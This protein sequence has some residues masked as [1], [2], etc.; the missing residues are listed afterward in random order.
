MERKTESTADTSSSPFTAL[1]ELVVSEDWR[2]VVVLTGAS[3]GI[4]FATVK[5]LISRQVFVFATVRRAEDARRVA[6]LGA[7]A[8]PV[9][10]DICDAER[11]RIV[12][13]QIGATREERSTDP[14][15][16]HQQRGDR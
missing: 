16:A 7:G 2:E 11:C 3:T 5:L 13:E 12:S 4:G 15:R 1:D 6:A 9:E 14:H 10:L 8:C